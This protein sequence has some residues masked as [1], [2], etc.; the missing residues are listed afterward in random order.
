MIVHKCIERLQQGGAG[1]TL[2]QQSGDSIKSV[3]TPFSNLDSGMRV[4]GAFLIILAIQISRASEYG[5]PQLRRIAW[6]LGEQPHELEEA[7]DRGFVLM[8]GNTTSFLKIEY[9][10][11]REI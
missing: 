2:G 1:A 3:P 6:I 7:L 10:S 9:S 5:I 4:V 11:R 8:T